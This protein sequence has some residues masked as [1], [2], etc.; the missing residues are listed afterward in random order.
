M[1]V[2]LYCSQCD[3]LSEEMRSLY[4]STPRFFF[5]YFQRLVTF[6]NF[7]TAAIHLAIKFQIQQL[8]D[9]KGSAR[10]LSFIRRDRE[11][12]WQDRITV[13]RNSPRFTSN[14]TQLGSDYWYSFGRIKFCKCVV[15]S[16]ERKF[17][18]RKL[19]HEEN[20]E[21]RSLN[22]LDTDGYKKFITRD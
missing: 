4:N 20:I 1:L 15:K 3:K 18:P 7:H 2:I 9:A 16:A 5:S 19:K 8:F 13:Q 17:S 21:M 14:D 6:Q 10:A 11:Y 22:F 12:R